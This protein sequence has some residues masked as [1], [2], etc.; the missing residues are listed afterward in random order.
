VIAEPLRGPA[1]RNLG[2]ALPPQAMA[3]WRHG[4]PLKA[5]RYLGVY[6]PD[7]MLCVGDARIGPARQRWWAL[8]WPDGRLRE[9]TT[10][11][12]GG[13]VMEPARV[14][15]ESGDVRID[16]QLDEPAAVETISPSDGGY[17]WTAKRA[18]IGVTGIVTIGPTRHQ[19]DGPYGFV[20][21]SAGYHDRHTV[22]KWS[23]GVGTTVDGRPVAWNL[24]DGIHDDPRASE[25]T[26]WVDGEP[27]EIGVNS[28]AADLSSVAFEEGGRLD[29]TEWAARVED[30][31]YKLLKSRYRQPFGTFAGELP[32]GLELAEGYGVMEDH[33]VHW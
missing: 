29:F 13:V 21:D 16:L 5:W 1:V 31:D 17:V 25:R 15:V 3:G 9:R 33:D 10:I 28:F 12:R 22:W 30:T 23:A 26:V 27:R 14:R 19:I 8:A 18:P 6:T 32:G 20:D 4:R 24:V 7:L 11:R 2:L